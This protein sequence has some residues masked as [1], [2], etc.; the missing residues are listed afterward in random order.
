LSPR[1]NSAC[2]RQ[3]DPS[4][5][6]A[7]GNAR[8][9]CLPRKRLPGS[10]VSLP[11][12]AA[13]GHFTSNAHHLFLPAAALGEPPPPRELRGLRRHRA[14]REALVAAPKR[15]R[16]GGVISAV[17]ASERPLPIAWKPLST[18][19]VVPVMADASGLARNAA[20][21]ATSCVVKRSGS[22]PFAA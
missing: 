16:G 6:S 19:S 4:L 11:S 9:T 12:P 5:P 22:G 18:Y 17:A 3:A 2:P 20:T 10:M 7:S 15:Q 21:E 14:K 8:R 13:S 1:A